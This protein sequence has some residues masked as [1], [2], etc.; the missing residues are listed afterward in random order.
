MLSWVY[1]RRSRDRIGRSARDFHFPAGPGALDDEPRLGDRAVA[2]AQ[3]PAGAKPI[4]GGSQ[5]S[6][7]YPSRRRTAFRCRRASTPRRSTARTYLFVCGGLRIQQADEK[8]Y[9]AVLRSA[10]RR[11][12]VSVRS[13][14][15][16]I[17]LAR[18]GLLAGY[19]CTIHW[20]NR[21]AFQEDFPD[22]D[23]TN[24]I[25]EI[26]RDRSHLLGRDGRDGHDAAPDRRPA[27]RRAGTRRREPV[28]P[29]AHPRRAGGPAGRPARNAQPHAAKRCGRR[30]AS[31][32]AISRTR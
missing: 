4:S 12:I 14:P 6:T 16:P 28:P 31:C 32:S 25:Y 13:R 26:D 22:L 5:A 20:E 21:S 11:G 27:R 10:A 9:L 30:S 17:L 15:E 3:S 7:A 19:R 29:R 24:K 1:E 23:C 2:L 18:A 8:R